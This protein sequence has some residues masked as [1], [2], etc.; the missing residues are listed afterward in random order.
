MDS[1]NFGLHDHLSD[2][3]IMCQNVDKNM[4]QRENPQFDHTFQIL[5]EECYF[6]I[7]GLLSGFDIHSM[8]SHHF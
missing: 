1:E 5:L 7:H 8:N 2:I 4:E 3:M 6:L